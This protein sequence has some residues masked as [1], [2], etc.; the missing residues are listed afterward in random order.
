M[1]DINENLEGLRQKIENIAKEIR[2]RIDR[3]NVNRERIDA[4][5]VSEDSSWRFDELTKITKEN[6]AILEAN[7]KA[8]HLQHVLI[9]L[10]N[11]EAS[12]LNDLS[13]RLSATK[14]TEVFNLTVSGRLSLNDAHPFAG[15]LPFLNKLLAF[16]ESTEEYEKC[17]QVYDRIQVTSLPQAVA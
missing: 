13:D 2:N 16:Y 10:F 12:K 8:L 9:N 15:N 6:Q 5:M 1:K 3:F 11:N 4:L 7:E 17:Q 14:A